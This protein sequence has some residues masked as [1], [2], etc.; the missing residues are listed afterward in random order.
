MQISKE[1]ARV[2]LTDRLESVVIK[3]HN[4]SESKQFA[5]ILDMFCDNSGWIENCVRRR[6][7]ARI[8]PIRILD[9]EILVLKYY[10][11][12]NDAKYDGCEI[13]DFS[14]FLN[15]ISEESVSLFDYI[16]E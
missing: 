3:T 13:V 10:S 11:S 8:G 4:R 6:D 9:N 15:E 14:S 12:D 7:I 16:T 2:W 5:D 1:K